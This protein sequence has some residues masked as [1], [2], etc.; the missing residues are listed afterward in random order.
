MFT[1]SGMQSESVKEDQIMLDFCSELRM[2]D[3]RMPCSG[4]QRNSALFICI[5][6][7]SVNC[8]FYF[9]ILKWYSLLVSGINLVSQNYGQK[10]YIHAPS[11]S[12][13]PHQ[14]KYSECRLV[15]GS[16]SD[17]SDDHRMSLSSHIHCAWYFTFYSQYAWWREDVT[18]GSC[19]PNRDS[20]RCLIYANTLGPI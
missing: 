3:F 6:V 7:K 14:T 11:E 15:F 9:R 5:S 1:H 16:D 20:R 18:T 2:L 10:W 4:L 8:L 19:Y 13:I 17:C 12:T